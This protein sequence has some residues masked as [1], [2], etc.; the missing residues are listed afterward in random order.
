MSSNEMMTIAIVVCALMGILLFSG[1][2]FRFALHHRE[3]SKQ[4]AEQIEKFQ[5]Q[6]SNLKEEIRAKEIKFLKETK[7]TIDECDADLKELNQK[8]DEYDDTF[9]RKNEIINSLTADIQSRD[10]EI[11]KLKDELK[12]RDA[13]VKEKS[14]KN[15]KKS[16]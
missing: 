14:H 4:L 3:K 12:Q 10:E 9:K 11:E 13:F 2:M 16:K 15:K 6:I 5:I 7:Q 8:I 1:V